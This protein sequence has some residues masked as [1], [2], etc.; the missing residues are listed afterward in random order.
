MLPG[1]RA[2]L[3]REISN[4][5][6]CRDGAFCKEPIGLHGGRSVLL[7][8]WLVVTVMMVVV[9]AAAAAVVVV[10]RLLAIIGTLLAQLGGSRM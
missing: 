2:H 7:M 1:E 5:G 9:A 4:P 8:L 6:A 10:V 3:A